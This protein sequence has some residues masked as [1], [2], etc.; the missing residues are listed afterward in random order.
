MPASPSGRC[1]RRRKR[2]ANWVGIAARRHGLHSRQP[3]FE[4][5]DSAVEVLQ[6]LVDGAVE[7]PQLLAVG[8]KL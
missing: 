5:A 4:C 6:L 2:R 7:V 3:S 8:E 1:A